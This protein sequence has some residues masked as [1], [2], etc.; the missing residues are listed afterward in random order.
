MNIDNIT[1]RQFDF[2]MRREKITITDYYDPS[3]Q[4][5]IFFRRD[6]RG[7]SPQGKLRLFYAVDTPISIGTI[8]ILGND[9]YLVTSKEAVE[10]VVYRSSTAVKCTEQISIK[11]TDGTYTVVPFAMDTGRYVTTSNGTISIIDGS[12]TIYTGLN[13]TVKQMDGYYNCFGGRYSVQNHLYNDGIAYI[14]LSREA[15]MPDVYALTYN[16]DTSIELEAGTYQL[17]Y[18]ASINNIPVENP[19]LSYVSGNIEVATVSDTGLLANSSRL[20]RPFQN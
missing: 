16:G 4:Y 10:G 13:D 12:V 19:T 14:Y 11:N 8:F 20:V 15:D 18:T 3:I 1:Q 7:T 6:N 17:T 9:N 5:D 2:S